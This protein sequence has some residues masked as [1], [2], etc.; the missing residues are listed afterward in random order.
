MRTYRSILSKDYKMKPVLGALSVALLSTSLTGCG[1]IFGDS[2]YFR[3][4]GGDYQLAT[5]EP[6]MTVPQG[7]DSKP[8]GDLLPVPGQLQ[9]GTGGKFKVPRPQALAVSG[10]GNEFTVQQSG[11]ARWLMAARPPAEVFA[12]VRQFMLEYDVDVAREASG[13][14]EIETGWMVIGQQSGNALARRLVPAVTGS[15]RPEGQ[16]HRFRLR[17]EPGVQGASSEIHALHMSR[18]VG[19]NLEA[20]PQRSENS[21][22]EHALLAELENY[23]NQAGTGDGASLMAA[24]GLS[25][26]D[27]ASLA[28]DGA[29]NPVLTLQ[30]DFNRAWASVGS[31]LQRAEIPVADLNRSAGVYYVDLDGVAAGSDE[32]GFFSRMFR[33]NRPAAQDADQRIQIRL[34]QL[35]GQ[36]Q[37]TVERSMQEAANVGVARDLLTR[38]RDNLN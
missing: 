7:V 4:R 1:Y 33:R 2:G 17:I 22:L 31:A 29:G 11:S 19:G 6:R 20:W 25:A 24:R 8:I 12:G 30:G 28:Q 36:V 21:N 9:Q 10:A 26:R 34:T 5:V 35:A 14:G 38:I 27:R 16:E 15:R 32:R 13:V 3:D 37:V 23:L 18:S